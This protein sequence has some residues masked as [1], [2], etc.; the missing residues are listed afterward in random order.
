MEKVNLIKIYCKHICKCHSVPPVQLSYTNKLKIM[1]K[2]SLLG[3]YNIL[4]N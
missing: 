3:N 4:I 2:E 1:N